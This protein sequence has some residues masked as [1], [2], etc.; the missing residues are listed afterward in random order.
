MISTPPDVIPGENI[1]QLE[2]S[3]S[4][5]YLTTSTGELI[6]HLLCSVIMQ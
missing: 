2:E 6:L 1:S 4:G 3:G 5:S